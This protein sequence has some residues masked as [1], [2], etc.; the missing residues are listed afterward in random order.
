[1]MKAA[2]TFPAE[3]PEIENV[4]AF[5]SRIFS[6]GGIGINT[7]ILFEMAVDEVFSNIVNHGLEESRCAVVV[8]VFIQI[9]GDVISITFKD[10]G[11]PFDPLSWSE[12]DISLGLSER[13]E[14]GLGIHIVKNSFDEVHY[15]FE[16]GLNVFTL[17]KRMERGVF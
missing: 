7:V 3:I 1:M 8:E 11:K 12:P 4:Y 15:S 10:N 14:G 17:K 6:V 13:P 16:K 9:S 2:K 5:I